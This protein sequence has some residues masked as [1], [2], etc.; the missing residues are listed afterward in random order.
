MIMSQD[1]K[2][3]SPS[4]NDIENSNQRNNYFQKKYLSRKELLLFQVNILLF[5]VF[6]LNIFSA[7]AQTI[8]V[9]N[10]G[11]LYISSGEIFSAEG[12]FTN[13]NAGS[14]INEGLQYVKGNWIND[15]TFLSETG[16][17]T[18]WGTSA[19]TISGTSST[20]FFDATINN[21]AG[22]N[23]SQTI[24]VGGTL[25]LSLGKITTSTYEVNVTNDMVNA[26]TPYSSSCY[27]VGNLRR[28]VASSGSYNFPLGTATNY[29][30]ANINLSTS[31]G[32]TN[33]LGTF[34][35]AAPGAVPG[36]L[37]INGT[38]INGIL[39]Y[40]YWTIT[41]NSA[42]TSGTYTVWVSENGAGNGIL[43]ADRYG[44][45]KRINSSNPWQS[46]GTHTN[47]TQ[48][49]NGS[50]VTA[51]R[52]A[53]SSFSD[54]SI[55]YTS[56]GFPL[57]IELISF[58]AELNKNIVDLNWVTASEHNS[59]YFTIERSTDAVHFTDLTKVNASGN[60]TH[61]LNYNTIDEHPQ[62]GVNYYRL[63]QTDIDG[64]SKFSL[65][66]EINYQV[67]NFSFAVLPNPTTSDNLNLKINGAKDLK[68]TIGLTDAS[69]K[70][71]FTANLIPDNDLFSYKINTVQKIA[72]GYYI[73]EIICNGKSYT[74][75]II[76]Q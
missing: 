8:D 33:L 56:S 24:A 76:L 52:S 61:E 27:I 66:D 57:P 67:N 38:T 36:G 25:N 10:T 42:M 47:G 51:V 46:L 12:S 3:N 14:T 44:I 29:E 35:N 71:Y 30:F 62:M 72:A 28:K 45:L 6:F 1:R 43:A 41:P 49:V 16:K 65:I 9:K 11:T 69:G 34:T 50:T 63:K 26:I 64:S 55:G 32:F 20:P 60:S 70:K 75:Q 19:Q 21:S 31:T 68:I 13:S 18:F 22:V 23:L 48:S 7:S 15:G 39:D 59:D 5:L 40:G 73:V 54:F 4:I 74:R 2:I 17:V 37:T 58:N 53:L